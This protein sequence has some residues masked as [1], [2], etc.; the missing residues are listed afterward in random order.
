MNLNQAKEGSETAIGFFI[1]LV[2]ALLE[3]AVD[4]TTVVIGEMS[5]QGMLQK[6]SN[7]SERLE[8]AA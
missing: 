3:R 2:S 5:V 1:S 8:L 4:P 7:L 6:V